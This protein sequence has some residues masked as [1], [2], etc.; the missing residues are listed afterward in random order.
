MKRPELKLVGMQ[1]KSAEK[2]RALARALDI[3]EK[4]CGIRSVK[5]TFEDTFICPDIDWGKLNRTPMQRVI[6]RIVEKSK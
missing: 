2:V 5:V 4:E 3:I 1:L 6:R